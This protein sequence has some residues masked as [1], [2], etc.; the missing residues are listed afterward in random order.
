MQ[1]MNELLDLEDVDGR[2]AE[3]DAQLAELPGQRDGYRKGLA[4]A[5]AAIDAADQ[6]VAAAEQAERQLESQMRDQEAEKARLDE[7]MADITTK[8]A[9]EVLQREIDQA[10]E[11]GSAFETQA[12]ELMEEIDAKRGAREAA[13]EALGELEPRTEALMAETDSE[14]ARL[15]SIRAGLMGERNECCAGLP[16]EFV[17]RYEKVAARRRPAI[18]FLTS[19]ACSKC[20]VK[21]PA[22]VAAEIPRA[23][24][25][26]TCPSCKRLLLPGALLDE[27]AA[28]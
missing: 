2:I 19:G 9:Y 15:E 26:E 20:H 7:Q 8:Q 3:V 1:P 22:T 4:D 11:A 25:L 16:E 23:R 27:A 14:Q 12:L 17:A 24:S 13:V 6:A 28:S 21:P 5:R 10:R 18:A